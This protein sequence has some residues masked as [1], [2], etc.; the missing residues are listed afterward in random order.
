MLSCKPR[1]TG[2]SCTIYLDVT[3]QDVTC[4]PQPW[5]PPLQMAT[6]LTQTQGKMQILHTLKYLPELYFKILRRLKKI[7]QIKAY[8]S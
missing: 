8:Q 4:T 1:H 3:I 5:G 2:Q 7:N 6:G